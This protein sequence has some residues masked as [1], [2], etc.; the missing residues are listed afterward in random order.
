MTKSIKTIFIV[1][2]AILIAVGIFVLGP[3]AG[4]G[5]YNNYYNYPGWSDP[6]MYYGSGYNSP[7]YSDSWNA[8]AQAWLNAGSYPYPYSSYY[9]YYYNGMMPY[10][11]YGNNWPYYYYDFVG[12]RRMTYY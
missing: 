2:T 4:Q 5:L 3:A 10:S 9:P 1:L 12:P 7:Y 8:Y 11:I 6:W